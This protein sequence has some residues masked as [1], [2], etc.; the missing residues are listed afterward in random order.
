MQSQQITVRKE[1]NKIILIIPKSP[2]KHISYNKRKEFNS[3][4]E[5]QSYIKQQRLEGDLNSMQEMY[6]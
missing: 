6:G 1:G 5:A 3:I 4:K 2:N